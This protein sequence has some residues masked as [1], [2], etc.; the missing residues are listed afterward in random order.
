MEKFTGD[1]IV[2][3]SKYGWETILVLTVDEKVLTRY[4]LDG[5]RLTA[6]EAEARGR[7]EL[8]RNLHLLNI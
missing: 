4:R 5:L 2:Q 8:N 6:E 1:V 3:K 7:L